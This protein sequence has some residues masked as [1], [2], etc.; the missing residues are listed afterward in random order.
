MNLAKQEKY[1]KCYKMFYSVKTTLIIENIVFFG[2]Q[3]TIYRLMCF[4]I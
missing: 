4:N 1:I 2:T 3:A